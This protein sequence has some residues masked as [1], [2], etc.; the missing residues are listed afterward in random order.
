M[1]SE[2]GLS[3]NGFFQAASPGSVVRR[4]PPLSAANAVRTL[5]VARQRGHSN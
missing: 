4:S 1:R 2:T 3:S 5:P